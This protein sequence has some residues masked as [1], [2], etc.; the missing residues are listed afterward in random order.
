[1]I[2]GQTLTLTIHPATREDDVT[3]VVNANSDGTTELTAK[4]GKILVRTATLIALGRKLQA[5]YPHV[6][7][8]TVE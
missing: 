5:V 2:T 1:M 4:A 3:I 6:V 7:N 8:E